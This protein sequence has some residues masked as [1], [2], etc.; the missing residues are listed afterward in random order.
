[1]RLKSMV[2]KTYANLCNLFVLLA[3]NAPLITTT[4]CC[5]LTLNY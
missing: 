4:H 5:F 1:M 3:Q 2:E